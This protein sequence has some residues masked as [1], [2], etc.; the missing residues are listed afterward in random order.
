MNFQYIIGKAGSGKTHHCLEQ[1]ASELKKGGEA[2]LLFLVPEQQTYESEVRLIQH[3]KNQVGAEGMIRA[4]VV[5]FTDLVRKTFSTVGGM[6]RAVLSSIGKD[7]ILRKVVD[8]VEEE[9]QLFQNIIKQPGMIQTIEQSIQKF[10]T[11]EIEP[12][13]LLKMANGFEEIPTFK[14]KLQDIAQIYQQYNIF[15]AQQYID[16]EEALTVARQILETSDYLAD[17]KIWI[18]GFVHMSPQQFS[19]IKTLG[20]RVESMHTTVVM[21][22]AVYGVEL[23][24]SDL[25]YSSYKMMQHLDLI[26]SDVGMKKALPFIIES[27]IPYRFKDQPCLAH[28]EQHALRY[29]YETFKANPEGIHILGALQRNQ[30]VEDVSKRIIELVRDKGYRYKDIMVASR[31][32]SVYENILASQFKEHEIPYF[33]DR[34]R[35]LNRHPAIRLI[36]SLFQIYIK[37]WNY[38]SVFGYLKTDLT[39]ISLDDI[40][41][42]ENEALARGWRGN[43]WFRE[44]EDPEIQLIK[45]KVVQPLQNFF[46]KLEQCETALQMTELLYYYLIELEIPQRLEQWAEHHA[47]YQELELERENRQIWENVIEVLD[48]MVEVLGSEMLSVKE[49]TEILEAG[50]E[51]CE[52][53]LIPPALDQ[54]LIGDLVRSQSSV[55]KVLFILGMNEGIF[56]AAVE[57]EGLFSDEEA[58]IMIEKGISFGEDLRRKIYEENLVGYQAFTR[59]SEKLYLSYSLSDEEGKALRP[60]LFISNIKKRFPFLQEE[61]QLLEHQ[62][63]DQALSLISTPTSTFKYLVQALRGYVDIGQCFSVWQEAYHWYLQNPDWTEITKEMIDALFYS[64]LEDG[65]SS[66][67][68]PKLYGKPMYSSVSKLETFN[69]CPFKFFVRYGLKAKERRKFEVSIPDIG[70]ILHETLKIFAEQLK[71][72][73]IPWRSVSK[74]QSNQLVSTIMDK[75]LQEKKST[76]FTSSARYQYLYS[77]LKRIVKRSVWALTDHIKRGAFEPAEVEIAFSDDPD[78]MPPI[79]IELSNGEQIKLIGRID[80]LD[81]LKVGDTSYLKVIDYKSGSKS[82]DLEEVYYGIQLQLLLYL[83]ALIENGDWIFDETLMPGGIFY[84]K[85]DDPIVKGDELSGEIEKAIL[86]QLKMSGLVLADVNVVKSIDSEIGQHSD[87]IPAGLKKDESFTSSSSVATLEQFDLLRKHGRKIVQQISEEIVKGTVSIAPKK[88]NKYKACTYC[89]YGGICQFDTLLKGNQYQS[90]RSMDKDEVWKKL[91]KEQKEGGE[92]NEC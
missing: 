37:H 88:N 49:Y 80:R 43:Q 22:P 41:I 60:S 45:Q 6:T 10:K 76:I 55:I 39:G 79:I 50:F 54:V 18:D 29:P 20:Q 35:A 7:M 8:E 61:L 19:F 48:Q 83:D 24:E 11:Y 36:L 21:D 23:A 44:D 16:S 92:K 90:I 17:A 13:T 58:R 34:K 77:R 65:I 42:L 73:N 74:E 70:T 64:N 30:E 91:Q 4:Q 33:L 15:M 89:D 67:H 63:E 26:V 2:P 72:Q 68:I 1:I 86:R 46:K 9:I 52:L 69:E 28:L 66:K 81:I 85:I 25:F 31:D 57:V 71:E 5:S 32:L 47:A 78:G 53:G 27:P 87:V 56:P 12:E 84:F 75:L 59:P 38:E 3:I 62:S 14:S 51:R 40:D 82:F